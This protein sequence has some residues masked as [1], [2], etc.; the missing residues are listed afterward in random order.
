MSSTSFSALGTYVF[1]ATRRAGDLPRAR[2]LAEQVLADIDRTCSRFRPDS[3]LSRANAGAGEWTDVDPLLVAAVAVALT[4]AEQTD[5]L[6]TPLLGRR[7]VQL[8]YDRDH[9]LLLERSDEALALS[10][11]LAGD[12]PDPAA[13]QRLRLGD[14]AI[15]VPRGTALDLGATGKAWAADVIAAAFAAELTG[16]ALVSLGG[17]LAVA[18]PD[19]DPWPVAI[20]TRPGEPAETTVAIDSGAL[21]TSSPQVRRWARLGVHLHHLLDP[22]TGFPAPTTWR[23]V[24]ATGPT[25]TAANTATT[26]AVVLGAEGPAWLAEHG[27]TAR[28]VTA[29]GRVVTTGE[30]PDEGPDHRRS[31]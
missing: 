29:D 22:R 4:A 24:T 25:C 23:T 17:D 9:G 27:V 16:S 18:A 11:V 3:D 5:G 10:G 31:A 30:W 21:A 19:G 12:P 28:L 2:R 1:L 6:V 20:S 8:G 14:G 7:L 15:R 13:W 26:T